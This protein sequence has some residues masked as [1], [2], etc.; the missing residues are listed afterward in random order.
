MSNHI[1]EEGPRQV[2]AAGNT[3][4][5]QQASQLASD[6]KYKARQ[7]MKQ[8]SGSALSPAQVQALYRQLLNASPAPGGVKSIVKQKLFKEQVDCGA[9]IVSETVK[10]SKSNVF[11]KIFVEGGGQKVE[12][13]I[14]EDAD[15]KFIVRVTDKQTG[16]T[17]YRKADRDKISQLRA[18]PNIS[19][20]EITGRKEVDDAYK[21]DPK[22]NYGGKKAKKDYDGDGK[23]E[24]G[25]KEHAGAVHNAIQRKKGGV[26]DGKD[27]RKEEYIDE[28]PYQVMGSPDG[29]KEKKIGKPVKS[30]K[31]ADSRAAELADTHK[32][33]GGQYRS[34]YVEEVIYEKDDNGE[35]KLDVMKKGKNA[36]KINPSLGESIRAELDLL[37]AQKIAEQDASM[38]QQEDE[39][40]KEQLAAQQ[41]KKDKMMKMRI[42]QN[43]M[44]AVR[45]GAEI[46]ASHELEGD[47]IAEGDGC[48]HTHEGQ[49][50]SVHGKV[51]CPSESKKEDTKE[52]EN[53]DPRSMPAKINLA[54]NKLRAMG[55]K[56]SYDMEGDMVEA[57][58]DSLKDRRM[59]R[60]GVDGNNRYNK[61]V[62]NTPN[63]FGKKKPVVGGPSALE[64]VKAS[65]TAKYGQGAI[66]DTKKK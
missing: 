1:F 45:G 31:Y 63:T 7:K 35:K 9:E 54:K 66:I 12:E 22:P 58:E 18:N 11:G 49:E 17:S 25:S 43:K 59:E 20:V 44:R 37:K 13:V 55:L 46:A 48:A 29:K 5:E 52:D 28:A 4:V 56:M 57:T 42:L 27:T 60:G 53:E 41:G 6:I 14:E 39:K 3:S 36:V 47:T 38:K 64:R 34:K 16:N 61:P 40:K 2:H 51:E 8:T 26:A 15:Q 62:S 23:V 30:R 50:C 32:T 65:I 21:G 19:S 10:R 33:T 24:S